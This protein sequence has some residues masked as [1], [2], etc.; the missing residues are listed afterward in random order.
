MPEADD[1]VKDRIKTL[2][3]KILSGSVEADNQLESLLRNPPARKAGLELSEEDMEQHELADAQDLEHWPDE[4]TERLAQFG[5]ERE[6]VLR[7]R[8]VDLEKS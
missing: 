7:H 4:R 2:L 8:S 6:L 5:S 3:E 1:V